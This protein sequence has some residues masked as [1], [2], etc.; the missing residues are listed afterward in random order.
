MLFPYYGCVFI[1]GSCAVLG[2]HRH[3]FLCVIV[4]D[5]HDRKFLFGPITAKIARDYLR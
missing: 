2:G 1:Y 4:L 5:D 3:E